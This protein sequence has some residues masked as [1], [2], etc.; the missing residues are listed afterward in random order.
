M[1]ASGKH[2]NSPFPSWQVEN[3]CGGLHFSYKI[4]KHSVS[5]D[6]LRDSVFRLDL[7]YS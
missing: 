6:K 3:K 7:W 2:D 1:G 4:C 5:K